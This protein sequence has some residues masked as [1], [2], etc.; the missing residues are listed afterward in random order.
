LKINIDSKKIGKTAQQIAEELDQGNP[1]IWVYAESDS[2]NLSIDAKNL[3]SDDETIAI[4][5]HTLNESEEE[6][7]GERLKSL[8]T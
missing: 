7:L 1:R 2:K 4:N 6:I 5:V 3:L 8:L